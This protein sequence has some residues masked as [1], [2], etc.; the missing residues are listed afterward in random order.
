MPILATP[1]FATPP[2]TLPLAAPAT[3]TLPPAQVQ[4]ISRAAQDFES[5]ALGQLLTP[6]FDTVDT[7]KGLFGGGE[8]EAAWK[9]MLV[10]ELA[11]GIAAHGGLGLARP[12]MQQMLRMQE[13]Q[14]SPKA[15]AGKAGA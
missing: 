12:V 2:Q 13:G 14:P 7:S 4:H 10:T 6:M 9:P 11:K 5:M 15:E 1:A 3:S 8:G